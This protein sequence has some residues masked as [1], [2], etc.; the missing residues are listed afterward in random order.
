MERSEA[1]QTPLP[2]YL[3]VLL[4]SA[5]QISMREESCSGT[6]TLKVE[7]GSSEEE[8]ESVAPSTHTN[9][10]VARCFIPALYSRFMSQFAE[11][12]V[13]FS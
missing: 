4:L 11:S 6:E 13:I 1:A 10:C 3:I 9:A 5:V 8:E 2:D 12:S 7:I